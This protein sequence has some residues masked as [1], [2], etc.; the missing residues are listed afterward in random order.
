MKQGKGYVSIAALVLALLLPACRGGGEKA[1]APAGTKSVRVETVRQRTFLSV[2]S[3]SGNVQVKREALVSARIPG[4]LDAIFV[5]EGDRVT[6]GETRL[7][8]TDALKLGKAVEA[9]RQELAVAEYGVLERQ[10][11]QEQVE[12]DYD[13]VRLDYERFRR[14]YEQDKAVTAS[15]FEARESHFL[16]MEAAKKHA[17]IAVDLARKRMEQARTSLAITEKDLRD[18]LVT[19]PLG[20]VVTKRLLEPGE[21]AGAG[22]PVL[23]IEDLSTVEVSAFLPE[24]AFARVTPGKTRVDVHVG[25][26]V[27][28]NRAVSYKSP[29][30]SSDLRTFEIRCLIRNPPAGIVPGRIARMEVLLEKREGPGVPREALTAR[31]D[32]RVVFVRDGD[33]ARLV[34]VSTGLE[35]DG[36][37]EITGGDLAPGAEVVT[38][39]ND[40]L[41]DGDRVTVVGKDR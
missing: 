40:L 26:T 35:T 34:E 1:P 6:A 12:A 10:A 9:A 25:D 15:A 24:E 27:L 5:D 3:P 2:L 18:S 32:G 19:A 23:R 21:M 22:T 20:G 13:K 29:T 4:A 39:G 16:Q 41:R 14:L 37:V 7:F 31:A 28:R 17:G 8:Q 11:N 30:V 33:R 36:W 38:A